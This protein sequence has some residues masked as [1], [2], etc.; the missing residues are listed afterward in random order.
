MET[1]SVKD[2]LFWLPKEID[3]VL[4]KIR[5]NQQELRC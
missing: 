3:Y 5:D 1:V 4:R 2:S